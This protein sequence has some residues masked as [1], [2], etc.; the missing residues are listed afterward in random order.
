MADLI[1]KIIILILLALIVF[2]IYKGLIGPI[3]KIG[4]K[5]VG[6][7]YGGEPQVPLPE[8]EK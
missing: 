8:T 2:V 3:L 4:T 6:T 1:K 5:E 7:F